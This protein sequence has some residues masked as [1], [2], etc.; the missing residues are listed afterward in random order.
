MLAGGLG[1]AILC[2]SL[3]H[4]GC[5]SGGLAGDCMVET[6]RKY[7]FGPSSLNYIM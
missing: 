2:S 6:C 4:F 5:D 3:G 1:P 7:I